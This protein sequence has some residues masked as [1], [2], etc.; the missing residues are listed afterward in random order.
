MVDI[1]ASGSHSPVV[2]SSDDEGA[3]A[4]GLPVPP[5]EVPSAGPAPPADDPA[6]Q[7]SCAICLE[8][9]IPLISMFQIPTCDH[10]FCRCEAARRPI[11]KL[12][13]L[14]APTQRCYMW[15]RHTHELNFV[16]A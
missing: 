5:P 16:C 14:S 10:S 9:G 8:D 2:L 12:R 11:F 1:T 15:A 13:P 7:A 3:E 4:S 6:Q